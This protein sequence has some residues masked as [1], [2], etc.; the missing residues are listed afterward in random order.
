MKKKTVLYSVLIFIFIAGFFAK[1]N[2]DDLIRRPSSLQ[3][4]ILPTELQGSSTT[5][6][7]NLLQDVTIYSED[8]EKWE[9]SSKSRIEKS[10]SI[11]TDDIVSLLNKEYS[12]INAQINLIQ[13]YCA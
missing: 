8:L 2:Y 1:I 5:T 13:K 6:I 4:N 7:S 12:N 9:T 3:G 11:S 10:T